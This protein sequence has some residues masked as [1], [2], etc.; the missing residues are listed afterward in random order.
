MKSPAIILAIAF[1]APLFGHADSA[2]PGNVPANIQAPS[3]NK[4]YLV[5]HAEGAQ[6]YVCLPAKADSTFAW[7]LYGPQ[8]TLFA[9]KGNAEQV[10]THFL[11]ADAAGAGHPTWQANDSSRVQGTLAASSSDNAFVA[12]G[13]D[14]MVAAESIVVGTRKG[15]WRAIR[16]RHIRAAKSIHSGGTAPAGG[17][18]CQSTRPT[19]AQKHWC[20][21]PQLTCFSSR[22][23]RF[24]PRQGVGKRG[25]AYREM[26]RHR[27]TGA[28]AG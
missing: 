13:R 7:T 27:I 25:S 3:G 23:R 1:V 4:L 22:S 10:G 8:A 2:K 26:F 28:W 5:T 12:Q 16:A 11:S 20:R 14:S 17:A 21:I 24:A 19:L 15:R 6:N 9:G 18:G